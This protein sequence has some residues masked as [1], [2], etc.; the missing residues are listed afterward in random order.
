MI[1]K[2]V[3]R[4]LKMKEYYFNKDNIEQLNIFLYDASVQTEDITDLK[5]N[6]DRTIEFPLERRCFE[7]VRRKKFLCFTKTFISGMS[8]R[9]II[10]GVEKLTKNNIIA[11]DN[12][13][14]QFILEIKYNDISKIVSF[15]FSTY[16]NILK[17]KVINNFS[18]KLIDSNSSSFGT[19]SVFNKIGFTFEEYNRTFPTGI[20]T[21]DLNKSK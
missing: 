1:G 8:S 6:P 9:I 14:N 19:G 13:S 5:V 18:I 21:N 7:N 3:R 2:T 10:L 17:M 15:V 4:Y 12:A 16:E 11:R 20:V